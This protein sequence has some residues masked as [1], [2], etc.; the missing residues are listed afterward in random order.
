[1]QTGDADIA[2]Y[3]YIYT[4]FFVIL[5][6]FYCFIVPTIKKNTFIH[7]I[8]AIENRKMNKRI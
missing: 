3:F 1:M 6:L 5:E 8:T 2:I 7:G 4:Y